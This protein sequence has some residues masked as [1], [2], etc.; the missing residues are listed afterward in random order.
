MIGRAFGSVA[1]GYD[2]SQPLTVERLSPRLAVI[3]GA[4]GNVVAARG[5]AGVALV[6]GGLEAR[7][8]E[9]LALVRRE[10]GAPGVD[11]LF[12]THW[13]AERIGSNLTLGQAGAKIVAHENTR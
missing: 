9:L 7:S 10:L 2:V 1:D 8:A 12:N 13:H 11:V 6:D 3:A 4:G 5:S